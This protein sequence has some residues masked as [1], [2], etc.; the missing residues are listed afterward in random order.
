MPG[1]R[2][3]LAVTRSNAYVWDY[4]ISHGAIKP[5]VFDLHAIINQSEPLP[6]GAL[7]TSGSTNE[8][9]IVIVT[10]TGKIIFWES[11]ETPESLSLFQ[12]K[13]NS[14]DGFIN[15]MLSG[16]KVASLVS[17]E[18]AGFVVVFSTGRLAHLTLR[19]AQGKPHI[20]AQFL[21]N[22]AVN[23]SNGLFGGLKSVFGAG[24]W[25]ADLAAVQTC[26]S[27]AKSNMNIIACTLQGA[28]HIWEVDWLAHQEYKGAISVQTAIESALNNEAQTGLESHGSFRIVDFVLYDEKNQS[29]QELVNPNAVRTTNIIALVEQPGKDGLSMYT[30]MEIALVDSAARVDRLIYCDSPMKSRHQS[31][32]QSWPKLYLPRPCHTAVLVFAFSAVLISIKAREITPESQLLMEARHQVPSHQET[33]HIIK[34]E[35]ARVVGCYEEPFMGKQQEAE[36]ALVT[37]H[38]GLLRFAISGNGPKKSDKSDVQLKSSIEQAVFYGDI[39]GT[40]V[41]FYHISGKDFTLESIEGAAQSISTKILTSRVDLI[42]T[43]Q[44]MVEQLSERVRLLRN[45]A[46][47]LKKVFPPLSRS[48]KWN[49]LWD[50]E[51]LACAR[52]VWALFEV[53]LAQKSPGYRTNLEIAVSCMDGL[54]RIAPNL[55]AGETDELRTWFTKGTGYFD[56]II[57]CTYEAI[58]QDY[59]RGNR[60]AS[61]VLDMAREANDIALTTLNSAWVFRS[62]NLELYGLQ[63]DALSLD[64]PQ[65]NFSDLPEIWTSSKRIISTLDDLITYSRSVVLKC[66]S[67]L[68]FPAPKDGSTSLG[69]D[70]ELLKVAMTNPSLIRMAS[71]ATR[72]RLRWLGISTGHQTP[73]DSNH[74]ENFKAWQRRQILGLQQIELWNDAISLAVETKDMDLLVEIIQEESDMHEPYMNLPGRALGQLGLTEDDVIQHEERMAQLVSYIQTF[75]D[76]FGWVWAEPY[77]HSVLQRGRLHSFIEEALANDKFATPFLRKYAGSY[78]KLGWINEVL[79]KGGDAEIGRKDLSRA[80]DMLSHWVRHSEKNL[81]S[82]KVEANLAKLAYM[83]EYNKTSAGTKTQRQALIPKFESADS[84]LRLLEIQEKVYGHVAPAFEKAIDATAKIEL[85]MAE[86]AERVIKTGRK[87]HARVLQACFEKLLRLER[88]PPVELI[89]LLTLMDTKECG[90]TEYDIS[91]K[92]CG[93]ALEVLHLAAPKAEEALL[94]SYLE[95]VWK[96]AAARD[97]WKSVNTTQGKSDEEVN[98]LLKE[99]EICGAFRTIALFSLSPTIRPVAPEDCLGSGTDPQKFQFPSGD[100]RLAEQWTEDNAA[101]DKV[102]SNSL[103][104]HRLAYWFERS[105]ALT[106]E[107]VNDGITSKQTEVQDIDEGLALI[108]QFENQSPSHTKINGHA[109]VNGIDKDMNDV[110]ENYRG[111]TSEAGEE[112]SGYNGRY[113]SVQEGAFFQGGSEVDAAQLNGAEVGANA[114]KEPAIDLTGDDE[115]EDKADEGEEAEAEEGDSMNE[116]GDETSYDEQD[117]TGEGEEYEGYADEY[118]E[119]GED[120]DVVMEG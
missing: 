84:Q 37:K 119:N 21:R 95:L 57:S 2:H 82:A 39:P 78:A 33:V 26:P 54:H 42:R 1:T 58:K 77:Y 81:W 50:A 88:L 92:E 53:R 52:E 83:A 15:G 72:E 118:E 80:G 85:T 109:P 100:K 107:G 106:S 13:R 67:E 45:L 22:Q 38:A 64:S 17:A 115:E 120:E 55:D 116:G 8:V 93:L 32:L 48:T 70:S 79:R 114:P 24:S 96:R 76:D 86:F 11:V 112:T 31:G 41:D 5:L 101:D 14:A 91:G 105:K 49:L 18:H 23:Q 3:A 30:L 74:V 65:A 10:A 51:K 99:T 29:H 4:T 75:F 117:G 113:D 16:E 60:N 6:T 59:N 62:A 103:Q 36:L 71:D 66:D 69:Q 73:S 97:D 44:S 47:Y 87:G 35:K 98:R 94:Q 63:H 25:R 89:E 43:K 19:D 27:N 28:F 56:R 108:A 104:Q 111:Q 12:Q 102:V 40:L 46:L 110:A 68:V 90:Y 7:F 20:N 61:S 9:G 34:D